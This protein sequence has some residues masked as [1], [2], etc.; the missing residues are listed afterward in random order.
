VVGADP[1]SKADK[2]KQL[3]IEM[4]GEQEFLRRLRGES[5]ASEASAQA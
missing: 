3:G 2:A 4:I 1:G 5:R